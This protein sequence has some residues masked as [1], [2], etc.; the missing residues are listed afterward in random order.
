M[1]LGVVDRD[2]RPPGEV[3]PERQV[4]R[5]EP[6]TLLTGHPGHHTQHPVAHLQR[7]G[8]RAV[9]VELTDQP[10]LLR[11]GHRLVDHLVGDLRG[12]LRETGAEDLVGATWR[13]RVRRVA[14]L[15]VQ[16]HRDLVRVDVLDRD[17]AQLP[18]DAEG[19]RAP[20]REPGD[21]QLR[22][23][24]QRPL[25]VQAA[26]QLVR[27]LRKERQL[28]RLVGGV[29]ERLGPVQGLRA[30]VGEDPEELHLRRVEGTST[31]ERQRGDAQ[32]PV[33]HEQ[34]KAHDRALTARR[35]LEAGVATVDLVA[36]AEHDRPTRQHA[37]AGR[38]ACHRVGLPASG[39]TLARRRAARPAAAWSRP[40][41][42][43]ATRRWRRP[44][45]RCAR[46]RSASP[47]V[48]RRHGAARR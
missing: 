48:G 40:R 34:R 45:P 19:D 17:R 23:V 13:R 27:G 24:P 25:V 2:R 32:D 5:R 4:P 41:A 35:C 11:V 16:G 7:H 21:R 12:E 47:R 42:P 46:S 6:A 31:R 38:G 29:G 33:A 14:T 28:G 36:A 44:R 26:G 3:L 20:V 30:G 8:H 37:V 15:E 10:A 18:V 1:Q 43:R 22:D 9:E 39:R